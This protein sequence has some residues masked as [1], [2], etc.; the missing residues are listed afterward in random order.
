MTKRKVL[1]VLNRARLP[2]DPLLRL[3]T[4]NALT[5]TG[6]AFLVLGGLIWSNIGNLRILLFSAENPALPLF[7]LAFGLVIT[8]GSVVMG[9][10]IMLLGEANDDRNKPGGG[11]RMPTEGELQPVRI[12]AH[13]RHGS[14]RRY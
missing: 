10:A 11:R 4:I 7:M 14:N 6:V 3:L 12:A 8:L 9:S 1:S 13:S 5:G 2:K